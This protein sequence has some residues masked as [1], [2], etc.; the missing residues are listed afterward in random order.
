[1]LV[2]AAQILSADR[3]FAGTIVLVFQ[4]AEGAAGA[5]AMIDDGVLD[6]FRHRGRS[7]ES[8][9]SPASPA[10][11]FRGPPGAPLASFDDLDI[12]LTAPANAR[13][14]LTGDVIVAGS[15]L[16]TA[17]QTIVARRLDPVPA[18]YRSPSSTPGPPTT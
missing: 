6:R 11:D 10:G 17:L 9:T 15:A 8:T 3:D 12:V 4:P 14:C 7:A 16:L 5:P 18:S 13:Y 2:G 1:M